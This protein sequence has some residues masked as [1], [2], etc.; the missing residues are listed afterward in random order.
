MKE[1]D[2]RNAIMR[3]MTW[4][5]LAVAVNSCMKLFITPYVANNIGVEAYGYVTL[6]TTFTSY[7]DIISV[8]LNAFAGRFISV[9]YHR[10]DLKRAKRY[11]SSTIVADIFLALITLIPGT[12]VISCLG[13]IL[14]VPNR[15]LADVQVLFA[16]TLLKYLL[17]VVRTAFDTASFLA[18]RL[19]LSEKKQ[20]ISYLLQAGL[21]L[22]LCAFLTPHVWYVGA[23]AAVAAVYLLIANYRLCRRLTP[24]L[25]YEW[26]AWSPTAVKEIVSTGIWTSLNNLGNVL[27]S[28]LD[29]LITELMLNARAL[30]EIS[31]AKNLVLLCY[32]IIMKVSN[33]FQP[34]LLL[35]Y[36]ENRKDEL[37]SLYQTAIKIMGSACI[38]MIAVFYICGYD[39]LALWLPGQDTEFLFRATM[40]VFGGD[41]IPAAVKPLYYAYT[42]TKKVKVPCIV[43][44][45]MGS[46]NV[47]SMYFLIRFTHL[48]AYAVILTTLVINMV[49]FIDAPLYAAY[50]LRV[51]YATFYPAI[52]RHFV[53]T[54][55]GL[56]TAVLIRNALPQA[57]NWGI[58]AVK[59]TASLIIFTIFLSVVMF[60]ASERQMALRRRKK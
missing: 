44:I 4:S 17:T 49:H 20:S 18:N 59:G 3:N 9:A 47:I 46:A 52:F 1:M 54:G 15:L 27:N 6:A 24:K 60:S 12:V 13:T 7:I 11:Y 51:P 55:A 8:S 5:I 21:L 2:S 38:L 42:L 41:V 26:S 14:K 19:D 29:L 50:C 30:G 45:L 25:T 43:T 36:A 23:A 10:N 35:L 53:G 57:R 58:L 22:P 28:G 31:V 37:I 39:F 32:T 48:G 34:R 56:L 33:A 40:I 16:L